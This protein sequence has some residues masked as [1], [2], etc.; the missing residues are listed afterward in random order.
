MFSIHPQ[1]GLA[2][3]WLQRDDLHKFTDKLM[4]S[5]SDAVIM[6]KLILSQRIPNENLMEFGFK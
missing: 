2:N 3:Y 6:H 4:E 1:I 5:F